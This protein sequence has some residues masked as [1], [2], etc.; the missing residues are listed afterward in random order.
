MERQF[1]FLCFFFHFFRYIFLICGLNNGDYQITY[2][3]WFWI[4]FDW[5]F[6]FIDLAFSHLDW[7]WMDFILFSFQNIFRCFV[8]EKEVSLYLKL[9]TIPDWL[10]LFFCFL[11][12]FFSFLSILIALD[13]IKEFTQ[14]H[15]FTISN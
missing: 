14:H 6:P 5:P 1:F 11:L 2:K 12:F 13:C 4:S 9:L 15:H 3:I 7:L 8:F 10:V